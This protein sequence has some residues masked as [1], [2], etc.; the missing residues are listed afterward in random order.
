MNK[1]KTKLTF[2]GTTVL[3][4]VGLIIAQTYM[5]YIISQKIN[6]DDEDK[7]PGSIGLRKYF[8]SGEGSESLPYII[9]RPIHLYNL[10]RLQSL[11]A[12]SSKFYFELGK[13]ING[14][15]STLFYSG[16]SGTT[17][18]SYLDMDGTE[19][20][21]IG[22][23]SNPFFGDFE[24]NNLVID[25]LVVNGSPEDIGVFGYIAPDASV[26]DLILSNLTITDNGYGDDVADLFDTYDPSLNELTNMTFNALGTINSTDTYD[27]A[28]Y[29]DDFDGEY[30]IP[31][32]PTT[33]GTDVSFSIRSTN[34]YLLNLETQTSGIDYLSINTSALTDDDGVGGFAESGQSNKIE[35]R[36]YLSANKTIDNIVYSK[37]LAT[38]TLVFHHTSTDDIY[39]N[40]AKD[41][42]EDFYNY[43]HS[44]N[45]G[46]LAGHCD[47]SFYNSYVY[48]GHFD[49]NND[50]EGFTPYPSESESGLIGEAGV[51]VNSTKSPETSYNESGDTGIINFTAI[52]ENVREDQTSGYATGTKSTDT[53]TYDYVYFTP[54][55]DSLYNGYLR[56]ERIN[57]T[58]ENPAYV[59]GED[60]NIDFKGQQIIQDDDDNDRG[61]G[62]FQLNTADYDNDTDYNNNFFY[63]LGEFNITY[64][65]SNPLDEI[66]YST[67]EF[68]ATEDLSGTATDPD[69][70]FT[71]YATDSYGI[72]NWSPDSAS[73][74][75]RL[76]NGTT[77]PKIIQNTTSFNSS[78]TSN[79]IS[80]GRFE[81]NYNYLI[82][83][84]LQTSD[85]MNYKNY[86]ADTDNLFLQD[87]F[88][89]K[90][91]DKYGDTLEPGDDNFGVMMKDIEDGVSSNI[92]SFDSYLKISSNGGTISTMSVVETN[93]DLTQTTV[94]YPS[95]TIEFSVEADYGANVTLVAKSTSD[96]S[97]Y[98]C[99][100]D[101]QYVNSGDTD[102]GYY[103]S[104]SMYIPDYTY[105][106]LTESGMSSYFNYSEDTDDITNI[107]DTYDNPTLETSGTEKLYA[108][109]FFLPQGEYFLGT[110]EG[111]A[112]VY[113]IAAQGQ[114]GK[115]NVS[116]DNTVYSDNVIEDLDFLLYDPKQVDFDIDTDRAYLSFEGSFTSNLGS[117]DVTTATDTGG[118]YYLVI[119]APLDAETDGNLDS[120]LIYNQLGYDVDFN[121][122]IYSDTY[123][124]YNYV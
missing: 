100:Y 9:T 39:L 91:R 96:S 70:F 31:S 116:S 4:F 36:I 95:K 108:H 33:L 25:N 12:F 50:V 37:I 84:D 75:F 107:S 56:Q 22:S 38:Y 71:T 82:N 87:Y 109:T 101:K 104:Y 76:N 48:N 2:L 43:T 26:E 18:S 55:D 51:N 66:Y 92:T 3:S 27:T 60:N 5:I 23:P 65:Y 120:L 52:Y 78:L 106:D 21:S 53:E 80:S 28:V 79:L 35:T 81:K 98:V 72:T 42:A 41:P 49:F 123:I 122:T 124:R 47:G 90:L 29:S 105:S 63:G 69:T 10:G 121:G 88:T 32:Y 17:T 93:D 115:G 8:D 16:D 30:F 58:D 59:T 15:G 119:T 40:I 103:P 24:G 86:F 46:M 61:L 45:V 111:N 118:N 112:Y 34:S 54:S 102:I 74:M 20:I 13:D 94:E 110:P 77:F 14:D 7:F 57:T 99:I 73:Q 62:I 11:G 68:D 6:E 89:Y 83:Y 114:E 113:Y 117:V 1:K 67:A 44:T 97:N 85:T 64:D 19:I